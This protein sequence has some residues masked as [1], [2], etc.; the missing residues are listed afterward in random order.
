MKDAGLS[1]SREAARP[2][3][4]GAHRGKRKN[5]A[6]AKRPSETAGSADGPSLDGLAPLLDG[7]GPTPI[8]SPMWPLHSAMWLQPDGVPPAPLWS[9]LAVEHQNRSLM[10][11][12]QPS[13]IAPFDHPAAPRGS[14]QALDPAAGPVV[15]RSDLAPLG[16]DP[17]AVCRK[18]G[19]E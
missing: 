9:G 4:N 1:N 12:F 5:G 11:D 13:G 15:P 7:G 3:A 10:P 16:W 18:E 14:S 19:Q 17:R 8:D 2:A 6:A